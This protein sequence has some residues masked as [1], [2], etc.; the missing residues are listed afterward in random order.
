MQLISSKS[1]LLR[2][3]LITHLCS[4][5]SRRRLDMLWSEVQMNWIR[6]THKVT[7]LF[8]A[9]WWTPIRKDNPHFVCSFVN[10][11]RKYANLQMI[12]LTLT[13][14][15]CDGLKAFSFHQLS[16]SSWLFS[17]LNLSA[18]LPFFYLSLFSCWLLFCSCWL[19]D[20]PPPAAALLKTFYSSSSLF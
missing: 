18:L 3:K 15:V 8:S 14:A 16:S 20:L 9:M 1:I 11:A 17:L 6:V 12:I 2:R 7:S 4:H 13:F 5:A 10:E 19:Y